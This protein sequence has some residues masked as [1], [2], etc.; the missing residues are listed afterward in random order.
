MYFISSLKPGNIQKIV[1]NK[2][3]K[4]ILYNFFDLQIAFDQKFDEGFYLALESIKK[5][6]TKICPF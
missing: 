2:T 3:P 4:I 6:E 5:F 1:S